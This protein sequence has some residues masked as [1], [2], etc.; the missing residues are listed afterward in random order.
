MDGRD[1]TVKLP[2][3]EP[4]AIPLTDRDGRADTAD[5]AIRNGAIVS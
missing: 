3:E 5:V 4:A 2:W 1:E